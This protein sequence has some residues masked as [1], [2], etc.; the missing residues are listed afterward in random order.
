MSGELER[1]TQKGFLT[2]LQG[3]A[4]D[5]ALLSAF[6]TS[7]L[8]REMA[9][10]KL[11]RREFKFSLL[12][13]QDGEE[14]LFQGVVDAW[15]GDEEGITVLDFKSDRVSQENAA[16]KAEEYRPQLEAYA[17]ALERILGLPVKRRVIWFFYRKEAVEL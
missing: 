8:G 14:V 3:R 15:F 9:G 4:V 16:G 10:A 2:P 7:P 13:P 11:L 5:P 12:V 6:V 17:Q 1:L